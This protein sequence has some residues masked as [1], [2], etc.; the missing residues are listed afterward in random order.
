MFLREVVG[1]NAAVDVVEDVEAWRFLE[2]ERAF[3]VGDGLVSCVK[4]R[5]VGE[6]VCSPEWRAGSLGM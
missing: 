5:R 4:L 1:E 3:G 2:T 6:A